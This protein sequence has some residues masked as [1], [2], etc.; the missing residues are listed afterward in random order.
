MLFPSQQGMDGGIGG[1][2][3]IHRRPIQQTMQQR[4]LQG[5]QAARPGG[6][7]GMY[8]AQ[9]ASQAAM[10]NQNVQNR[11]QPFVNPMGGMSYA[12]G[13][14]PQATGYNQDGRASYGW[15]PDGPIY[16]PQIDYVQL[17]PSGPVI[18][19]G[20]M[21]VPSNGGGGQPPPAPGGQIGPFDR[22]PRIPDMEPVDDSQAA[23][24]AY[25]RAKD[26][27]GQQGRAALDALQDIQGGRGIVG[28]GIGVNEAGGVIGEAARQLGDFNSQQLQMRV[29]NE[30][31]RREIN[32]QGGINQ[33]GQDY[34]GRNTELERLRWNA[35]RSP[36]GS[37]SYPSY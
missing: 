10:Q 28:S 26:V 2:G 8:G 12:T 16:N 19:S 4:P 18:Q 20:G 17:P 31:R 9:Q 6:G 34:G 37:W 21:P 15:G 29:D 25:A 23:R 3:G 27:A 33:R 1:G 7:A 30:R 24:E 13:P 11:M 5:L 22:L 32:Y 36:A 14:M 35:S